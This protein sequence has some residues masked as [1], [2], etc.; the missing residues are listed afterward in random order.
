LAST[1]FIFSST[2]GVTAY[3]SRAI[4]TY[5]LPIAAQLIEGVTL[6]VIP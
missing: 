6:I 3:A 1:V 4:G 2:A 5:H